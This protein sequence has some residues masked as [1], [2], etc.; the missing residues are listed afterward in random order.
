MVKVLGS[1]VVFGVGNAP[2]PVRCRPL[3]RAT[4]SIA[5]RVRELGLGLGSSNPSPNPSPS[6]LTLAAIEIVARVNARAATDGKRSV[7]Y[8]EHDR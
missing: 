6:S 1:T 4:I 5:A 8:P 7:T 3:T 2:F